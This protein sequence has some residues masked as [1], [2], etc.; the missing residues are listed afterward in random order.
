MARLVETPDATY[1]HLCYEHPD[2]DE[3]I[4]PIGHQRVEEVWLEWTRTID[5]VP[6]QI[7]PPV[8]K[9]AVLK[10]QQGRTI[11]RRTIHG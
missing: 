4:S 11:G 6:E 10:D 5:M 8:L 9:G 3:Y 1:L 2:G 7:A